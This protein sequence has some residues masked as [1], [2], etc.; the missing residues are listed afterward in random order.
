MSPLKINP[1][2]NENKNDIIRTSFYILQ[3]TNEYM[4]LTING[5]NTRRE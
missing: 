4:Y 3:C 1:A 2:K 5:Y